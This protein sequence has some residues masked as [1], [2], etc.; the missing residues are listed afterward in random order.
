MLVSAYCLLP[1][2][3]QRRDTLGEVGILFECLVATLSD[4]L[5]FGRNASIDFRICSGM[6]MGI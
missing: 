4:P 2:D 3:C 5:S 6:A 1:T